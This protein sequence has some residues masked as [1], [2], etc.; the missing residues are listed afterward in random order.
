LL[1]DSEKLKLW[2][3]LSEDWNEAEG[4]QSE[5]FKTARAAAGTLA[6]AAA[7]PDVA[8]AMIEL[9]CSQT[10]KSLLVTGNIELVQ[11][12]LVIV[13]ELLQEN[14]KDAALHLLENGITESIQKASFAIGEEIADLAKEALTLLLSIVKQ[15]SSDERTNS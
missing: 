3:A 10:I 8:K 9:N 14:G 2:L 6:V 7:E 13:I 12:S 1:K 15:N 11:R 5:S 4:V